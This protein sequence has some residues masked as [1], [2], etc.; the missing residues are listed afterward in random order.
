MPRTAQ[1]IPNAMNTLHPASVP[2]VGDTPT[3]DSVLGFY[4]PEGTRRPPQVARGDGIY[5]WAVRGLGVLL[6]K[7][8]DDL[9]AEARCEGWAR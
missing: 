4:A 9:H 6:G 1:P 3:G 5:L 7:A 2:T 8:L